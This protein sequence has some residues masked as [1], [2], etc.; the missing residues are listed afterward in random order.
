MGGNERQRESTGRE[1]T[2][3]SG[4]QREAAGGN[5]RQR[6]A[7]GGNGRQHRPVTTHRFWIQ[8]L[9]L[10]LQARSGKQRREATGGNSCRAQ[11]LARVT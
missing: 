2:G 5:G 4:R 6:E 11:V 10:K 3:G 9:K 1:A 8:R 7:T